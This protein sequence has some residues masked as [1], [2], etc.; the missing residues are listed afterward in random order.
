MSKEIYY[1]FV[2]SDVEVAHPYEPIRCK[3]VMADI[4]VFRHSTYGSVYD[5]APFLVQ[6]LY[7]AIS[8]ESLYK[9]FGIFVVEL[10][11]DIPLRVSTFSICKEFFEYFDCV[12]EYEYYFTKFCNS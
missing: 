11:H 7:G 2:V 12:R 3:R 8:K 9:D 5:S 1:D 6:Y 4:L 10:F